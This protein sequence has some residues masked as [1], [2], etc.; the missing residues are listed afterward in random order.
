VPGHYR[1]GE[2]EIVE[3]TLL[4][5]YLLLILVIASSRS[6][7]C[8]KICEMIAHPKLVAIV[9]VHSLAIDWLVQLWE[10]VRSKCGRRL[11]E[12]SYEYAQFVD[13]D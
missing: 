4:P 2:L 12:G 6:I 7:S 13:S 10:S 9:P 8:K 11:G 5:A 1:E 3:I